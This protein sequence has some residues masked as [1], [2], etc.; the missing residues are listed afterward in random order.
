MKFLKKIILWTLL[1]LCLL[2]IISL[3][4]IIISEKDNM[5]RDDFLSTLAVFLM[6]IPIEIGLL[7]ELNF[8]GVKKKIAFLNSS[9][10]QNHILFW[11]V[12]FLISLVLVIGCYSNVSEEYKE[13][14]SI[15][16]TVPETELNNQ[17]TTK[18][19]IDTTLPTTTQESTSNIEVSQPDKN[20]KI[21]DENP[22][23]F[24]L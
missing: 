21:T 3:G 15:E 2:T 7:L 22:L 11:S 23:V 8:G 9:K 16:T 5:T 18:S 10:V 19:N 13:S 6:F 4:S 14:L 1:V 17:S 24:L 12:V 20:E